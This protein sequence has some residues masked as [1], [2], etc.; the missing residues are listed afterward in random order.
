MLGL[1]KADNQYNGL[2]KADNQLN[3]LVNADNQHVEVVKADI[4][5]WCQRNRLQIN[6]GK[7]KKLD[8]SAPQHQ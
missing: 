4:V 7:T 6:K 5:D 2:V 3:G 8:H 1:I